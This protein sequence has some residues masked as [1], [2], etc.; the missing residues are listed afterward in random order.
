MAANLEFFLE[1][2]LKTSLK[3]VDFNSPE[4]AQ[5]YQTTPVNLTFCTSAKG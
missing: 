4:N 5:V 1:L 3:I 2:I